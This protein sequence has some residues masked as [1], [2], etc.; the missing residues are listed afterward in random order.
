[1]TMTSWVPSR[2]NKLYEQQKQPVSD[3]SLF[4]DLVGDIIGVKLV[5]VIGDTVRISHI[6]G[7]YYKQRLDRAVE[8]LTQA[9]GTVDDVAKATCL[10][11]LGVN[12]IEML[13]KCWAQKIKYPLKDDHLIARVAQFKQLDNDNRKTANEEYF[14][15][16]KEMLLD[17]ADAQ[18]DTDDAMQHAFIEQ[19]RHEKFLTFSDIVAELDLP[20]FADGREDPLSILARLPLKAYITT[21]CHDFIERELEAANKRP[22]SRVC[23]WWMNPKDVPEEQHLV[24]NQKNPLVYHL[25]GME[26]DP[27]SLVLSEDD[28]IKLLRALAKDLEGDKASRIITPI[29]E[30]VLNNSSLLLL[31]YRLQDWDLG[32][33]CHGLLKDRRGPASTA[34]HLDLKQQPLVRDREDPLVK[35]EED[36]EF[37]LA[38]AKDYLDKYFGRVGLTVHIGDSDEFVASLGHAYEASLQGGGV[39][40]Q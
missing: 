17:V 20:R 22:Q 33:L 8:K 6:F 9:A 10:E 2:R 3:D 16:L 26:Q 5:P 28:N 11:Q 40:S 14:A 39:H 34:I 30:G 37:F 21:S 35:G 15:F 4:E 27:R 12:I 36:A 29:L 18:L 25:F 23:Y 19:L 13:A 38:A 32:V 7:D 31:G 1:M 24:P